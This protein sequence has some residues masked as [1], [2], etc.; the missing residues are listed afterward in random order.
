[1]GSLERVWFG[2]VRV[3]L[4]SVLGT[5]HRQRSRHGTANAQDT[6]ETQTTQGGCKEGQERRKCV[7]AVCAV[8]AVR[9]ACYCQSLCAWL[10]ECV[11]KN[12]CVCVC[13]GMCV[14]VCL[15]LCL[16]VCVCVCAISLSLSRSRSLALCAC[17]RAHLIGMYFILL[18]LLG[19]RCDLMS[20]LAE[21]SI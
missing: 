12:A 3:W 21:L 4:G 2:S 17:L 6:L 14:C 15:C 11:R 19:V 5:W 16:C 1:L 20:S 13:V 7:C 18:G 8:C 9:H 10:C